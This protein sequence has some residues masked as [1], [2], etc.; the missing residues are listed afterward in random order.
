MNSTIA[1]FTET[2]TYCNLTEFSKNYKHVHGYLSV[3]VCVFGSITNILNLCVLTTKEMRSPTNLI[4]TGLA[5]A[6]LLVMLEYIPYVSHSRLDPQPKQSSNYLSYEWAIFIFGHALFTLTAH[7]I[8]CCLT[9]TLAVWRYLF[10]TYPQKSKIWCTVKTTVTTI[11]IIYIA[12]TLLCLPVFYSLEIHEYGKNDN[13]TLKPIE[14]LVNYSNDSLY[15]VLVNDEWRM[16]SFWIY[17]CIMK[18]LPCILLTILSERLISALFRAKERRKNLLSKKAIPL[19][20]TK[21]NSKHSKK[22]SAADSADNQ[23]DRTTKMLVAVLLLFLITEFPQ[24]ILGLLSVIIGVEFEKQCY[25][26]LGM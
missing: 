15:V 10:I 18:L 13:G 5:A 11:T 1:N 16:I 26:T 4:L 20:E 19:V 7:F 24:A 17:G 8:S 14:Q 3:F 12:C 25:Q 22:P 2:A 6:D 23:T 9:V 21:R